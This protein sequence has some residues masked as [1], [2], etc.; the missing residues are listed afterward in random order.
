MR[1]VLKNWPA[2]LSALKGAKQVDNSTIRG[3]DFFD[4]LHQFGIETSPN[5][6]MAIVKLFS[7]GSN[8]PGKDSVIEYGRFL[9]VFTDKRVQQYAESAYI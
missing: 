6:T 1:Q 8:R 2:L 9:K 4:I 7:G 3:D 5:T